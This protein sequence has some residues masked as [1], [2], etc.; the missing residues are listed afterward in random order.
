MSSHLLIADFDNV[1]PTFC[2]VFWTCLCCE[3]VFFLYQKR[4]MQWSTSLVLCGLPGL[5]MLLSSPVHFFFLRINHLVDL[6]TPKV[7]LLFLLKIYFVLDLF[8]DFT[9]KVLVKRLPNAN[10]KSEIN[11]RP[12]IGFSWH[13]VTRKWIKCPHF[14][15]ISPT[16]VI[17]PSMGL[18]ECSCHICVKFHTP[19][20]SRLLFKA[21]KYLNGCV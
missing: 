17:S 10:S 6:A 9:F 11:S 5:L 12:F 7:F 21:L 16:C 14:D 3:G 18:S 19:R 20:L 15:H 13:E 4:I 2:R 8:L 1:A